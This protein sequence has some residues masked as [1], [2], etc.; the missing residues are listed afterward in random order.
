MVQKNH[1]GVTNTR[2]ITMEHPKLPEDKEPK[3]IYR[4][5]EY[6]NVVWFDD[7]TIEY[8]LWDGVSENFT[9]VLV[10]ELLA[11]IIENK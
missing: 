7:K 10:Y 8:Y 11:G 9:H 4:S 6:L 5:N 2:S 3:L 1:L